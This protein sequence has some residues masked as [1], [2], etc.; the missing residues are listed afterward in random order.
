MTG[1]VVQ[2]HIYFLKYDVTLET[3][4][5]WVIFTTVIFLNINL[6]DKKINYLHT[7]LDST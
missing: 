3:D 1:F 2:G 4:D 7:N 5:N 6:N